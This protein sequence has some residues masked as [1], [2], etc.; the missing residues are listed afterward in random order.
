[1]GEE[2]E[3]KL[4]GVDRR[5]RLKVRAHILSTPG[6]AGAGGRLRRCAQWQLYARC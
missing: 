2:V 6:R 4:D 3:S 5:V 1:M